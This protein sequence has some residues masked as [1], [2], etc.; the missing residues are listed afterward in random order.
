MDTEL[1]ETQESKQLATAAVSRRTKAPTV[2]MCTTMVSGRLPPES[3]QRTVRARF[4]K[5][6]AC[7]LKGLEKHPDLEGRV[8]VR[9]L[10]A[11]D[12]SVSRVHV[13]ES[14]IASATVESCIAK[15]F[16]ALQF[17]QPEGGVIEVLYPLVLTRDPISDPLASLPIQRR[18]YW[19]P[20]DAEPSP[21]P[22]VPAAYA[23]RFAS[24]MALI[25][26]GDLAE[27]LER[28]ETWRREAPN[29]VMSLIALGEVAEARGDRDLAARAYGSILELW[30]YR[31]DMRRLAG[32]RLERVGSETALALATEAYRGALEDRP[33][34]PS[35]HRL[36][37]MALLR[38][39]K[40]KQAF[41]VLEQAVTRK[42]IGERFAGVGDVLKADL[43]LVGAVWAAREPTKAEG[44][45]ARLVERDV[46]IDKS[47]ST[48]FVLVWESDTSDVDLELVDS[49]GNTQRH[50]V[51]T[52]IKNSKLGS[53]ITDGYGPEQLALSGKDDDLAF[54][55]EVKAKFTRRGQAGG[56]AMG[57]VD[58]V[59]HDGA[60]N[61]ELEALPFVVMEPGATL[62][63][64]HVEPRAESPEPLAAK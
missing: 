27:A 25:A 63:L 38:Q 43:A 10:I 49:A 7:Y 35:S 36:Y 23:G 55:F 48:R 21:P 1:V 24:V 41:E 33:D 16:Q 5:L 29:D 62:S 19:N 52:R 26:G 58:V 9:F 51:P 61:V 34:H 60:G 22:R 44:I 50:G 64:G 3:V 8:T 30:S 11:R 14:S 17:T 46:A 47:P 56:F 13:E 31:A 37:A 32:E 12:G 15:E 42:F 45:R 4:G 39:G 57:K 40:T 2:R 18:K 54:P 20:W 6:R 28:V 53:N 59:R